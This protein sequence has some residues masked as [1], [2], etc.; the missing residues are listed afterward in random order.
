MTALHEVPNNRQAHLTLLLV[1]RLL[2]VL[3]GG[4]FKRLRALQKTWP[5]Q[6][7]L[8]GINRISA[9]KVCMSASKSPCNTF[10][11]LQDIKD[12]LFE[13]LRSFVNPTQL[14]ACHPVVARHT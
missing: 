11:F 12:D 2:A 14:T 4:G 7:V 8:F 10:T 1:F 9:G 5:A 3:L 13:I 6:A